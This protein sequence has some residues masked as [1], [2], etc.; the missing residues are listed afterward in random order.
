MGAKVIDFVAV[1]VMAKRELGGREE[2]HQ[3]CYQAKKKDK[4][5]VC[6]NLGV[7]FPLRVFKTF[8][9][10]CLITLGLR[11]RTIFSR[12]TLMLSHA[13]PEYGDIAV[14]FDLRE[15]VLMWAAG[16][17]RFADQGLRKLRLQRWRST[18][19]YYSTDSVGLL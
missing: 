10:R 7:G 17:S 18:T 1:L 13:A 4:H 19:V 11:N 14:C 12:A 9:D 8:K 2:Q 5:R 3:N 15:E 6:G 16:Q